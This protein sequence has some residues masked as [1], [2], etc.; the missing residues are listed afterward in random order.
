MNAA[1]HAVEIA[2]AMY[3]GVFN[4]GIAIGAWAGG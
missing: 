4:V 3:V 2:T 1:P